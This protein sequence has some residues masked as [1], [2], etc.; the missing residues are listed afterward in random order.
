MGT[1]PNLEKLCRIC[2]AEQTDNILI[3]SEE[4]KKLYLEA[5][6]KKYLHIAVSS[7]CEYFCV[8]CQSRHLPVMMY[9]R[10]CIFFLFWQKKRVLF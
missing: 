2:T 1:A 4:G 8:A 7:L 9:V 3:F 10:E 5:K 6:M